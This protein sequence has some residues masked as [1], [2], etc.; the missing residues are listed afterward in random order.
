MTNDRKMRARSC[1]TRTA[2]LILSAVGRMI[3]QAEKQPRTIQGVLKRLNALYES[4]DLTK[5][6]YN[7]AFAKVQSFEQ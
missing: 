4:G 6:Q 7:R 2:R 1:R 3:E 5:A